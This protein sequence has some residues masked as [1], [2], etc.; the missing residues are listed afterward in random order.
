MLYNKRTKSVI[1]CEAILVIAPYFLLL[2]IF[3]LGLSRYYSTFLQSQVLDVY[4]L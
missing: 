1:K 2:A 4:T 3:A